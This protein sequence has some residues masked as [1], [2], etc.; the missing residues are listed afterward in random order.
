MFGIL[1]NPQKDYTKYYWFVCSILIGIC[2]LRH[3]DIG[4]DTW[5]YLVYFLNP[6]G[7]QH[8]YQT[9][10][11]IEPMLGIINNII[12][13]VVSNKYVYQIIITSL[14][15]TPVFLYYKKRSDNTFLTL[16][17]YVTFSIA[18]APFFLA[19]AALRQT[20]ACAFLSIFLILYEKY[21]RK[22]TNKWVVL[23]FFG[24]FFCHYTSAMVIL[25]ILFDRIRI[26][27][28]A[29]YIITILSTCVGFYMG[30]YQTHLQY[31]GIL[32][33]GGE[34]YFTNISGN[35]FNVVSLLPYCLICL[36]SIYVSD[37]K[38]IN[39]IPFKSL[40]MSFVVMGIMSF[41]GNNV[42]RMAMYFYIPSYLA[43][44]S[45]L[46]DK[47]QNGFLRFTF[48]SSILGYF[49]YKYYT[50]LDAAT[51]AGHNFLPYVWCF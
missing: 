25:L 42:D 12:H 43:I 26:G 13:I 44:T 11:N 8:H 48:F 28:K 32:L 47:S 49:I 30:T 37:D 19:W 34:F 45:V 5:G 40:I 16:F 22:L 27:K 50:T 33:F 6:H 41:W 21:N 35:S 4:I 51:E 46:M 9:D 7:T 38:R 31:L 3:E 24:M 39:T 36:Y 14:M 23:S 17:L 2:G 10:D 1:K 29:L 15:L 18:M 20:L